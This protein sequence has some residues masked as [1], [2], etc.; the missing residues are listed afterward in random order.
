MVKYDLDNLSESEIED[1]MHSLKHPTQ[2]RSFDKWYQDISSTLFLGQTNY[3]DQKVIGE[4]DH[5]RYILHVRVGRLENRFSIHLRFAKNN[6]HLLRLDVGTGHQNPDGT[7]VDEDHIH[8]YVSSEKHAK[9]YAT[10]LSKSDF[11]NLKNLADALD[12]FIDYTNVKK[13]GRNGYE[14]SGT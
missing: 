9:F 13:G 8:V 2:V 7:R 5:I 3:D 1:I 6:M 14:R 11:P 10:P 4:F 12:A